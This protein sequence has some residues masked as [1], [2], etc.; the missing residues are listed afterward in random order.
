[1]SRKHK[2]SIANRFVIG[3]NMKRIRR[4]ARQIQARWYQ[5]WNVDPWDP[6]IVERRNRRWIEG[7]IKQGCEIV[8]IGIDPT[9]NLRSR[10]YK[11]EMQILKDNHYPVIPYDRIS[12]K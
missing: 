1:M 10:F 2:G 12:S 5:G 6:D 9:R 4:A 3:E 7:K 11:M 8:D